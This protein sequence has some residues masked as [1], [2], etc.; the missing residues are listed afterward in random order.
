MIHGKLH[1]PYTTRRYNPLIGLESAEDGTNKKN[2]RFPNIV[3]LP[4]WK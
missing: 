2:L 3:V 4:M 1:N